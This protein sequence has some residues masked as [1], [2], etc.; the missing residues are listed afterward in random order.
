MPGAVPSSY[1]QL[2][3]SDLLVGVTVPEL[4]LM[5]GLGW[6]ELLL[7]CCYSSQYHTE[8]WM[9]HMQ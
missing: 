5:L 8:R 6:F 3:L 9:H 2:Q 7:W 1:P 4:L